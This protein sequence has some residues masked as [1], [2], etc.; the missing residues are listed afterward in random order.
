VITSL[1]ASPESVF[2]GESSTIAC[3]ASDPDDDTLTYSWTATGGTISGV[4]RTVTWIA[5]SAE[6]TFTIRVTVDDGREG[7]DTGTVAVTVLVPVTTGSISVQSNPAG[8]EVYLDGSDTGNIT[9][10]MITDVEEGPYTVRLTLWHYKDREETV[11][12]IAGETTYI[13]WALT[14]AAPQ[15]VMIQPGPAFG[16]DAYVDEIAANMNFGA[17]HS[18]FVGEY[19]G[20]QLNRAYLQFDLSSISTTAVV[21][22]AELSLYYH[23]SNPAQPVDVGVYEVT[24]V[25]D[26]MTITWNFQP[27]SAPTPEDTTTVPAAATSSFISWSIDDLVQGWIDGS[28]ANYGVMLKDIDETITKAFKSFYASDWGTPPARPKLV[29]S[30]FDPTDP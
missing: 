2:P 16:K 7:T 12:V 25:W 29:I 11:T 19:P 9:P 6:G 18:I 28:S 1:T 13:N 5:P 8:A 21:L 3:V 26:E 22:D 15:T 30:Y 17:L 20:G 24:S 27:T 14:H 23:T 4:G 10:Y